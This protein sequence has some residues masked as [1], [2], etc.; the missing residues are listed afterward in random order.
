MADQLHPVDRVLHGQRLGREPLAADH[1]GAL[2]SVGL[3]DVAGVGR[4]A[5]GGHGAASR[6]RVGRDDAV[7]G[8]VLALASRRL[9]SRLP[10]P[11]C[12]FLRSFC[13]AHPLHQ[14][15]SATSKAANLSMPRGLGPHDRSRPDEGHLHSIVAGG[16]VRLVV[17]A[18]PDLE[19]ERPFSEVLHPFRLLLHVG[20]EA[21]GD[22]HIATDECDVHRDLPRVAARRPGRTSSVAWRRPPR[23]AGRSSSTPLGEP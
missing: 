4:S 6:S 2:R 9:S 3:V 5:L 19:G 15:V 10:C 14:L 23:R 8:E 12:T 22:P 11:R 21:V 16:A 1:H 13:A 17:P 20:A 7:V 18:E